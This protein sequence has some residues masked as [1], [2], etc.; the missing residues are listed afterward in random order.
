[1]ETREIINELEVILQR[2]ELPPV[3]LETSDLALLEEAIIHLKRYIVLRN[4]TED[5]GYPL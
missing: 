2:A 1:M 5:S 4:R 3:C